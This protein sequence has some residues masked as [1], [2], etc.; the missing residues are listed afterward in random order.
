[1][2]TLHRDASLKKSKFPEN[3][4]KKQH[5]LFFYT[6]QIPEI[7][8]FSVKFPEFGKFPENLQPCIAP[9]TIYSPE[10]PSDY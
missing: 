8:A 9:F 10:T 7:K 2:E 1:M 4:L 6:T 3:V 5:F